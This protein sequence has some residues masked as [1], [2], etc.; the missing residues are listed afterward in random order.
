MKIQLRHLLAYRAIMATGS[1][2]AATK[3]INLSQP[4]ISRLLAMLEDEL[5][6]KLFYRRG[7][8]L[9][10][11][12]EGTSFFRRIEGTLSGIDDISSIADDI[13]LNKQGRLRICGIGPLVF[14]SYLPDAVARYLHSYPGTQMTLDMRRR[15][16]IDEW[17]ASRQTD[18]GFTLLPVESQAVSSRPLVTVAVVAVI[19][20]GH[21]LE[22]RDA[23]TVADFDGET[24]I[25]PKPGVRL[26][27][28]SDA[29][30]LSHRGGMSVD[31]ETSTA[32]ASVHL[33]AQGVG[34]GLS[35]PFSVSCV[36]RSR[37]S[38]LRWEPELPL[39]YCAIWPKDREP[40]AQALQFLEFVD[41]ATHTFLREFPE[42][43]PSGK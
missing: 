34:V 35:D 24:V 10:P 9:V 23:L 3:I 37:V 5:G 42:S 29:A 25:L 32:L 7:R 17:V 14:G 21:R 38:V 1:I 4:A 19:P 39:T 30:F 2:T 16:D 22:K 27:Q 26:R 33:I 28:L 8:R 43:R 13:R 6:F 40:S 18:L 20:A 31:I 12:V 15:E 36:D 11:T 41:E